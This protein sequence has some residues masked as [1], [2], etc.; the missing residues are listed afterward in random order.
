MKPTVPQIYFLPPY[1]KGETTDVQYRVWLT[2]KAKYIIA[3]DRER[4]RACVTNATAR[5]YK[6]LIHKEATDHGRFD[7]FTGEKLRWDLIRTWNDSKIKD[8][9]G[10]L[11]KTFALLPTVD[12]IDPYAK[13]IKFEICSSLINRSKN[14]LTADEFV[15][16]CEKI[17]AFR[18]STK[19]S[20]LPSAG[21]NRSHTKKPYGSPQLYF[22]PLFLKGVCTEAEYLRWLDRK[23]SHLYSSDKTLKRPCV[24]N[25]TCRVYKL[26]IHHAVLECGLCCPYTGEKLR[27]DLLSAWDD[28][29][30]KNPDQALVKKFSG[31]PTVDHIDPY[32]NAPAFEIC[33]WLVNRCKSEM[34]PE[35]FIAQCRKIIAFRRKASNF[36]I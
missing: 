9:D 33:S 26:L 30:A 32:G 31:L 11:F 16:L 34:T 35:E 17:K 28:A 18:D 20:P 23:A 5:L 21:K 15:A 27:W 29:S 13:E 4:K 10:S 24:R 36:H 1:L 6:E 22:L 8:P 7:P 19:S 14:N 25:A 3:E 2:R 12:H